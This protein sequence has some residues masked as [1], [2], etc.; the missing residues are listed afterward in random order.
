MKEISTV[1]T[2]LMLAFVLSLFAFGCAE[3]KMMTPMDAKMEMMEKQSMDNGGN[4]ENPDMNKD[5]SDSM[6]KTKAM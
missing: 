4:R 3:Q 1:L 2:N 6:E 5:M